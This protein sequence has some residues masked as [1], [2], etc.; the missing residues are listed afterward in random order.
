MI[1]ILTWLFL[2]ASNLSFAQT[3]AV[4]TFSPGGGVDTSMKHFANWLKK[5]YN[6]DLNFTYRPGADGLVG[7]RSLNNTTEPKTLGLT[8]ISSLA[9]AEKKHDLRFKY[10]T[11]T[12]RYS[13]VL[14][15]KLENKNLSVNELIKNLNQTDKIYTW[16]YSSTVH[17]FQLQQFF[18]LSSPKRS[19]TLVPYKGGGQVVIDLLSGNIDFA[20]LAMGTVKEYVHSGRLNLL[21]SNFTLQNFEVFVFEQ[22]NRSWIDLSGFCIILPANADQETINKWLKLTRDYLNDLSV[23]EDFAKEFSKSFTHGPIELQ[24][25]IEEMKPHLN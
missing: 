20:F 24:R 13:T 12:R 4:V 16:G 1:K 18:N 7:L 19:Q 11:A 9:M 2:I 23:Q 21:A 8:N 10:V 3:T 25:L 22:H 6:Y 14:V 17:T 15:S 5:N